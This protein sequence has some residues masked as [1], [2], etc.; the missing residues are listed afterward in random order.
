M[1]T[2][3]RT[4]CQFSRIWPLFIIHL[5]SCGPV[6]ATILSCLSSCKNLQTGSTCFYSWPLCILIQYFNFNCILYGS[7]KENLKCKSTHFIHLSWPPGH[8]IW[9]RNLK[10]FL[11]STRPFMVCHH[12]FQHSLF[13]ANFGP[14]TLASLLLMDLAG[15]ILYSGILI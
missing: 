8:F 14:V 15:H 5:R 13:L 11:W 1:G 7:Q 4:S 3:I 9:S 12:I 2:G 10:S 6:W